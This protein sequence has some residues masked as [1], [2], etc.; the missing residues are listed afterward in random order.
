MAEPKYKANP[1][2]KRGCSGGGPPRWFPSSA[3]LC[4]DDVTLADAAALL[5]AA[6]D[7]DDLTHPERR[8]KYCMDG[9]GRFFKAYTEDHGAT[10]HGYPVD[11]AV[12]NRQVP[13]RVLREFLRTGLLARPDYT[14]LVGSGR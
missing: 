4:P 2:H 11:R 9:Q 10:W 5:A 3:S 12:V 7:G 6:V 14:R 8:A 13:A 1:K